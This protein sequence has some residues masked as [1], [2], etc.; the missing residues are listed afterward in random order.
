MILSDLV[1]VALI[2]VVVPLWFRFGCVHDNGSALRR[3]DRRWAKRHPA[4]RPDRPV[5]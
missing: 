3:R 4:T 2:A 5:R 1:A